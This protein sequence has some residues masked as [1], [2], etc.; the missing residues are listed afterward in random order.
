MH[1]RPLSDRVKEVKH[2]TMTNAD[3]LRRL[4]AMSER[5]FGVN[6]PATQDLR[7]QLKRAE[8]GESKPVK[9]QHYRLGFKAR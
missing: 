1:A 7:E 8:K 2:L 5:M 4:T 3:Y 6:A 9:E